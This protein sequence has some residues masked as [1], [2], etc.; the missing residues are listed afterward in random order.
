MAQKT[1]R[2]TDILVHLRRNARADDEREDS[3]DPKWLKRVHKLFF[4]EENKTKRWS[5]SNKLEIGGLAKTKTN[6]MLLTTV[7]NLKVQNEF[8]DWV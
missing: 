6:V 5:V 4:K 8:K 3:D 1:G 7:E 2:R